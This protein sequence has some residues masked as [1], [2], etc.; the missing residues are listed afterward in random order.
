MKS[1]LR[2]RDLTEVFELKVKEDEYVVVMWLPGD[3]LQVVLIDVQKDCL[4]DKV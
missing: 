1:D 3:Y 4:R 2:N